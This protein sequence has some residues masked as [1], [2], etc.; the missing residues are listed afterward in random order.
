MSAKASRPWFSAA[1][2][3]GGL[4]VAGA[5]CG[6]AQE[7]EPAPAVPGP[8]PQV[9]GTLTRPASDAA[10]AGLWDLADRAERDA[11]TSAELNADPALNAYLREVA[12]R[13]AAGHCADIRLYVMNRPFFN[14]MMAP[15]GYTEIWSGLLLRADNEAE[16]AFVIGHEIGHFTESHSLAM[17]DIVRQRTNAAMVAGLV[18]SV[19]A[20][21]SAANS[22]NSAGAISD[23]ASGLSNL[24][25]LGTMASLF[26]FSRSMEED[27][28]RLGFE[29]ARAAGYDPSA[30]ASLWRSLVTE[31]QASDSVRVRRSVTRGSV[32]STHPV[33]TDRIA[34]LDAMAAAQ[35]TGGELNR[36]RY[37]AAIR[38]FLGAWLR[39]DL[40]RRDFGQTLSLIARLGQRGED[41]GVLKYFEGETYRT[42][43]GDG[44][45]A[46]AQEAYAAAITYPDAPAEAWREHGTAL[47]RAGDRP[48]AI[49]AWET[50]LARAP[51]ASDR[52]LYEQDL[53]ALRSAGV[54]EPGGNP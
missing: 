33:T 26:G 38:P 36:E 29:R 17:Q 11:R 51:E 16:A 54:S 4:W 40:R 30:G 15:N 47:L 13:V 14:A 50:Y 12:C 41:L 20:A 6:L 23:A 31:T 5:A 45:L 27:A 52:A 3:A 24:V 35:G 2:L 22:P 44:D 34:A 8:S 25:Y 48:G 42:R 28:D 46:R 39:D 43:R 49:A 32:F 37:R 10:G 7:G 1:L 19:A 9:S 21:G 53:Q 18:I